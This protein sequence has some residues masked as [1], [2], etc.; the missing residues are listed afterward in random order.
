MGALEQVIGRVEWG[1]LDIR[2]SQH[3]TGTEIDGGAPIPG[4][5][6]SPVIDL[7]SPTTPPNLARPLLAFDASVAR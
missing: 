7:A 1:P 4:S 5:G 6:Y 3:G 2:H